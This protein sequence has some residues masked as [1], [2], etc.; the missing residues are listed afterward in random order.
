M[1]IRLP[2]AINNLSALHFPDSQFTR[3]LLTQ[4]SLP[5]LV[6]LSLRGLITPSR[7]TLGSAITQ[8]VQ[9]SNC[10][11]RGLSIEYVAILDE[12]VSD[13]LL[14]STLEQL[15]LTCEYYQ[16][17]TTSEQSRRFLAGMAKENSQNPTFLP[18]LRTLAYCDHGGEFEASCGELIATFKHIAEDPRRAWDAT[19]EQRDPTSKEWREEQVRPHEEHATQG[20]CRLEKAELILQKWTRPLYSL[21]ANS[22]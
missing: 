12:G 10:A 4:L 7:P 17:L 14:L 20:R 5:A 11:L 18:N 9:R 3:H 6:A 1:G 21:T 19:V 22:H 13:L 2:I 15:K 16:S 8:L